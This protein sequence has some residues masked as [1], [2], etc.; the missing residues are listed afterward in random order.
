MV[1][2]D[3]TKIL[4]CTCTAIVIILYVHNAN[5]TDNKPQL[6]KTHDWYIPN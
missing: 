2:M 3:T 1:M 6:P 5:K 4:S